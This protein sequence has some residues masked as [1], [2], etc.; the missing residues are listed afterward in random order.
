MFIYLDSEYKCYTN[1]APG[2]L[3]VETDF[4]D[5]KCKNFIEG[6]RFVPEG[7]TWTRADGEKFV[8]VMVS[9]WRPYEILQEI[10]EV[11]D[12]L[13]E[14]YDASLASLVDEIYNSDL[15]VIE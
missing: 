4:F 14:Y 6:Y 12:R 1:N 8:G 11:A 7:K 15:E 13:G 3:E 2:R 5:G 10:Q 9:P